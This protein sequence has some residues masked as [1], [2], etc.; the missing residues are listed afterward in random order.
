MTLARGLR[1]RGHSQTIVTPAQSALRDEAESAGITVAPIDR[2]R[3]VRLLLREQRFDILHAHSGRGQNLAFLGALGSRLPRVVTRHVAFT[4]KHPL[5]HR[6]K[7]TLTCDAI[8]AVSQ[9]V[10]E[11]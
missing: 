5:V 4:P 10:R 1:D 8:I 6:L 11:V 7:Y 2:S 9:S 3:D